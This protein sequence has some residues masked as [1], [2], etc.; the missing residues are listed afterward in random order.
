MSV[1]GQAKK[2]LVNSGIFFLSET[3]SEERVGLLRNLR[4]KLISSCLGGAGQPAGKV[5]GLSSTL[6]PVNQES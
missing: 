6:E 5:P 1:G 3:Y 4:V 2:S